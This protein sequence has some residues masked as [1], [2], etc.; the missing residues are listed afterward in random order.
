MNHCIIV[1]GDRLIG[2]G[3]DFFPLSFQFEKLWDVEADG[4]G[5]DGDD[6][7]AGR[8]GLRVVV[9]RMADREVSEEMVLNVFRDCKFLPILNANR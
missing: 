6:V 4:E 8:P 3:H 5:Q 9:E 1:A 7:V 2:V